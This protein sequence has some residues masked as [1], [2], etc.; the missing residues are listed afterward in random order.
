[1]TQIPVSHHPGGHCADTGLCNPVNYHGI[2][3]SEPMCFGLGAGLEESE[4]GL[5][6]RIDFGV[7]AIL[8]TDIFHLLYYDSNTHY[9][10]HVI[11]VRGY[12]KVKKVFFVT[13]TE[14]D[15]ALIV[16]FEKNARSP[17]F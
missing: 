7:P 8:Q 15:A 6:E 1:M 10:G 11:T 3:L 14:R 16:P 12:D 9:P 13:D 17:L 5:R 2:E 4:Q